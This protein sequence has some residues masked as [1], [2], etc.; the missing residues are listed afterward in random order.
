M[1]PITRE[2]LQLALEML[3]DTGANSM[4]TG[5][6]ITCAVILGEV[7]ADEWQSDDKLIVSK[8]HACAAE[9]AFHSLVSHQMSVETARTYGKDGGLDTHSAQPHSPATLGSLG[10]GYPIAYGMA[11]SCKYHR[12]WCIVG[13]AEYRCGACQEVAALPQPE[14]LRLI[15]DANGAGA[16][17]ELP[18]I[19]AHKYCHY[20]GK[21]TGLFHLGVGR[22]G[23]H[24]Q[25]ISREDIPHIIAEIEGML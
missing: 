3:A 1:K 14:R 16:C 17:H 19:Q 25:K 24:Y 12:V 21:N 11:L 10:I 8:A 7:V 20:L 13:D 6:V 23:A 5:S 2:I 9:Y 22:I 18:R 4:P 15:I